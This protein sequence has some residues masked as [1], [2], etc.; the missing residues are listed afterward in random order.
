MRIGE[1]AR[2]AAVTT[3]AVRYY[4]SIGLLDARRLPNGYRDY[5][6]ND[7]RLVREVRTLAG[8]GITAERARP[9]LDCLSSGRDSG[10]D[11]PASLDGYRRAIDELDDRIRDLSS[12]REAL[13]ALLDDATRRSQP[14]CEFAS[15]A[16]ASSAASTAAAQPR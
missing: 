7:V 16:S 15:A 13:L 10:D 12:R 4:E 2:R 14:L 1:L 5:D 9:F 3:K 6:E 11:C 8:L